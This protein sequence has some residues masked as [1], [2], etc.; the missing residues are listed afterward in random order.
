[1]IIFVQGS[2]LDKEPSFDLRD[3]QAHTEGRRT[4]K[5]KIAPP[6]PKVYGPGG[7]QC[8]EIQGQGCLGPATLPHPIQPQPTTQ[9]CKFR[10]VV[11]LQEYS[12]PS[13]CHG[14]A[15]VAL[16]LCLS[17]RDSLALACSRLPGKRMLAYGLCCC[18][19]FVT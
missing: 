13:Y 10:V 9:F 2:S 14:R 7:W 17:A 5:P 15:K 11:L 16:L 4:N 8:G 1:M 6:T 19:S 3:Q 18:Q 12:A